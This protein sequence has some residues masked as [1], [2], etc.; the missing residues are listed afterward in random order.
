MPPTSRLF[1]LSV[2]YV[3]RKNS[4]GSRYSS[5]P[6]PSWT[7]QRSAANSACWKPPLA[8]STCGVDDLAPRFQRLGGGRLNQRATGA[9]CVAASLFVKH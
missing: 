3:R 8:T 2:T 5:L 7:C 1:R 6:S 9:A 4:T